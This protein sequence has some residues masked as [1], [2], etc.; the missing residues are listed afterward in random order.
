[1]LRNNTKVGNG[2]QDVSK[3]ELGAELPKYIASLKI[4]TRFL[5]FNFLQEN[6]KRTQAPSVGEQSLMKLQKINLWGFFSISFKGNIL[7]ILVTLKQDTGK[8]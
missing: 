2:R 6:L 7:M 8:F 1:M 4:L 5:L 3:S